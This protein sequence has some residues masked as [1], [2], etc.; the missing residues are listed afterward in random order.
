MSWFCLH[1]GKSVCEL[2][3]SRNAEKMAVTMAFHLTKKLIKKNYSIPSYSIFGQVFIPNKIVWISSFL[4]QPTA[5]VC[6]AVLTC[7]AMALSLPSLFWNRNWTNWSVTRLF[8]KQLILRTW[9]FNFSFVGINGKQHGNCWITHV[10]HFRYTF[11]Y[12]S[13]MCSNSARN[14]A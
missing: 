8:W 14:S 4:I 12:S 9:K 3:L 5:I 2:K 10:I 1:K 7:H 6:R 13:R 11:L